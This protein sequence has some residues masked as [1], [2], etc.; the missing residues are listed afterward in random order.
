MENL[1]PKN[2]L[3]EMEPGVIVEIDENGEPVN[4]WCNPDMYVSLQKID[5]KNYDDYDGNELKF[6][7]DGEAIGLDGVWDYPGSPYL[8]KEDDIY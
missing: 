8:S 2:Q 4:T 3:I 7:D 5:K 1:N 6:N